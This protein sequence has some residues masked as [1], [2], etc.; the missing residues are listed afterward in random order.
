M[1]AENIEIVEIQEEMERS[2]LEYAMSVIVAR[3]LPDVRDGLKPVHRRILW[4]M[5]SMG[6]R[7]DR[8]FVKCAKVTGEVMGNYH[9]HGDMAIYDALVRLAQPF[10]L[11][12]P[13][14]DFHGNYGSPDDPP[15]AAR[16]TE[17][18]LSR[19]AM[20]ML[21]GIEEQTV[22][23][24]R[25]YDASKDEPV[26]LP[27]RFPNLLVN[28]SQGIAVGLATNIPPHSLSEAIDAVIVLLDNPDATIDELMGVV[29]GPDFPTG[30]VIIGTEGIREA[31]TTGRG[32]IRI[33]ARAE[34]VEGE[35]ESMIVV[36]ELPYQTSLES[37]TGR[38][39]ELVAAREIEGIKDVQNL[40]AGEET[41]LVIS[42]RRDANPRVVLNNLY[43]HTALETTFA[44]NMVAL[45]DGVPRTLNLREALWYY[46][47]HQVEVVRRRS[48]YRLAKARERAHIVEG[49]LRAISLLDEIIAAI[50]SSEDRPAAHRALVEDFGFSDMQASAILDMTLGRL[51]RLGREELESEL[52][53]L[54]DTIEQLVSVLGD[55]RLL[56]GVVRRELE[57]VKREFA[58]SRRTDIVQ[59]NGELSV[60]DLVA[61]EEIVVTLTSAGYIKAVPAQ[62]FRTQSRG[63]RGIQ[64]GNLK[65]EDFVRS[66]V[67]TTKHSYLLLFSN[68]GR[69]FR[70][71]GYEVPIRD[72]SARGVAIVNLVSLGAGES[73]CEMIA[74]KGS[75]NEG[76]LCFVTKR[77]LVKRTLIS[78]YERCKREGV[79]AVL[80]RDG[81]ELVRVVVTSGEE[82]LVL[83]SKRG[84]VIRFAEQE[85]RLVG[86]TA[87]GVIGMR[88][89]PG[90]EVVAADVAREGV[91]LLMITE[92][93]Y[94]KRVALDRF[95]RQGR[96][97]VGV[98]GIS[99]QAE[100]GGLV[101]AFTLSK[102]G[103]FLVVSSSGV[104]IRT[105]AREVPRQGREARGVRI[106]ALTPGSLVSAAA[107][108]V[109]AQPE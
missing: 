43:R 35:R 46:V 63:G 21:D 31:Y 84:M 68:K 15:A 48:E 10:A 60:E 94:G 39:K 102:D 40:S 25:N 65:E 61:D 98:K 30:G 97:G 67:H 7:P 34:I 36:R 27:A 58:D 53:E 18:R 42:L 26:V 32:S 20:V 38:I 16:Y 28:G 33:R 83:V 4:A 89:R 90:D 37:I 29:K 108:V 72:R 86:R 91:D 95:E 12:H 79:I 87:A 52:R 77:G 2:F 59:G 85:A 106:M 103:E 88:L 80:L 104:I 69:V 47:V 45:V 11:R 49:Y 92:L 6:L 19:L 1:P 70:V 73:V 22:D 55:E 41:S 56:R 101:A 5:N 100:R 109:V 99:L 23:F 71:R 17:C 81:D 96:G 75:G 93:G 74:I 51:T 105:A 8:P 107:P 62:T 13:L 76:T 44:V 14:V 54:R 82:D 24:E 3:A 66:V 50:R 78:E 64:A 9:P 57:A